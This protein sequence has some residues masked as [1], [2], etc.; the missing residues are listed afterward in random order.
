[1]WTPAAAHRRQSALPRNAHSLLHRLARVCAAAPLSCTAQ[2]HTSVPRKTR[3]G[4]LRWTGACTGLAA[5]GVLFAP[6]ES[7]RSEQ[8]QWPSEALGLG[9]A[10]IVWQRHGRGTAQRGGGEGKQAAEPGAGRRPGPA[11]GA[12]P[13]RTSA[14]GRP[15][16]RPY[17]LV[18]FSWFRGWRMPARPGGKA[19]HRTLQLGERGGTH[20]LNTQNAQ[21]KATPRWSRTALGADGRHAPRPPRRRPGGASGG[22]GSRAAR[23]APPAGAARRRRALGPPCVARPLV[24]QS[25]RPVG[26]T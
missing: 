25:C 5:P 21:G 8:R 9:G 20:A 7:R 4:P 15:P 1:M 11:R 26:P 24:R 12:P 16:W 17:S 22:R 2:A 6:W 3:R 23:A 19:R 18:G 10:L 13:A 14:C